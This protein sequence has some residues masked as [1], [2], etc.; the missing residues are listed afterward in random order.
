MLTKNKE[1]RNDMQQEWKT[2]SEM[3][4]YERE[5]EESSLSLFCLQIYIYISSIST[6][7]TKRIEENVIG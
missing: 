6:T 2:T 5:R 1:I 3:N 7:T 4:T